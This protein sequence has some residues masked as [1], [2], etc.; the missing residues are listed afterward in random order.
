MELSTLHL[1][2]TNAASQVK[3]RGDEQWGAA[4]AYYDVA[5]RM[6]GEEAAA[7]AQ[8]IYKTVDEKLKDFATC[9]VY[10]GSWD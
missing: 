10:V 1:L 5:V 7:I 8:V 2:A 3:Q 9:S 6:F 4:W